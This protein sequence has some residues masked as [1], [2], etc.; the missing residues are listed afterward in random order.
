MKNYFTIVL[1][2]TSTIIA[3]SIVYYF[4]DPDAD[5]EYILKEIKNIQYLGLYNDELLIF[6]RMKKKLTKISFSFFI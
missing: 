1:L 2:L 4:N 6:K 3:N 5:S